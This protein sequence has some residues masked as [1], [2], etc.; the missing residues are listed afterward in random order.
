ME[1][2]TPF[3]QHQVM[4]EWRHYIEQAEITDPLVGSVF[5][6]AG[7]VQITPGQIVVCVKPGTEPHDLLAGYPRMAEPVRLASGRVVHVVE[8]EPDISDAPSL[9]LWNESIA[10]RWEDAERF[11]ARVFGHVQ[12]GTSIAFDVGG[13]DAESAAAKLRAALDYESPLTMMVTVREIDS[14][15]W[16][17]SLLWPGLRWM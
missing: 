13:P 4:A 10:R 9:K 5:R 17:S 6:E 12:S 16:L 14:L 15:V 8:G 7:L 2:M 3:R 1:Q 11:G